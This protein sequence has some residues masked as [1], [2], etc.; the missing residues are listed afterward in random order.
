MSRSI[1]AL[2]TGYPLAA[3]AET[4][5]A[6]PQRIISLVAINETTGKIFD[7]TED[8]LTTD[9][10]CHPL[11]GAG[12]QSVTFCKGCL[13]SPQNLAAR[14]VATVNG[15]LPFDYTSAVGGAA[16]TAYDTFGQVFFCILRNP[17]EPGSTTLFGIRRLAIYGEEEAPD[18]PY[19]AS[20][21]GFAGYPELGARLGVFIVEIQWNHFFYYKFPDELLVMGLEFGPKRV[22]VGSDGAGFEPVLETSSYAD[23]RT[24]FA[25]CS[26]KEAGICTTKRCGG[27]LTQEDINFYEFGTFKVEG[28]KCV[29][30]T[31]VVQMNIDM[32]ST[33]GASPY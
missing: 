26:V 12:Q 13:T 11:T 1:L 16:A 8:P 20:R 22:Q 23:E 19:T 31:A 28:E 10:A 21:G 29:C 5:E 24:L 14:W 25:H 18:S 32:D 9:P 30:T 33:A 17:R 2:V 15:A 3:P 6:R 4:S 27:R 7:C